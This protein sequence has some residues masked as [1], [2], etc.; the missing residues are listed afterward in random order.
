MAYYFTKEGIKI[1]KRQIE[2]QEE[3]IKEIQK[4]AAEAAGVSYDWHDNFGYEE[5]KRME[6]TEITV[7]AK[8]KEELKNAVIME[9]EEQD[10]IIKIGTTAKILM[11]DKEKEFTIGAY[12][13]SDAK[14]G[15]ISYHSPLGQELM[16][17]KDNEIK[18]INLIGKKIEVK[19]VKIFPPSYKYLSLV[20][21]MG[22]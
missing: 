19:I 1:K 22:R 8:L 9:P 5:A 11:N 14:E 2:Q 3:K 10:K 18:S 7:L 6:E 17:M 15:L 20:K 21:N 16:N 13:E 12:G 4:E